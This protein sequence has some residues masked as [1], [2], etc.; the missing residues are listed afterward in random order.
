[1]QSLL[2]TKKSIFRKIANSFLILALTI[3][4]THGMSAVAGTDVK[5]ADH[6]LAKSNDEYNT[7]VNINRDKMTTA[8][9][10]KLSANDNRIGAFSMKDEARE[11]YYGDGEYAD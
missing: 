1:M 4:I 2:K 7:A 8:K 6:Q 11:G 3:S 5:N 9:K 10:N